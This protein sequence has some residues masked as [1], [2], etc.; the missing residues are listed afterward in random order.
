MRLMWI[1]AGWLLAVVTSGVATAQL[2]V[3][4]VATFRQDIAVD[5]R[6]GVYH[7]GALYG[8]EGS[9]QPYP[10]P[11]TRRL[12]SLDPLS[13]EVATLTDFATSNVGNVLHFT[14]TRI[15]TQRGWSSRL[16]MFSRNPV[17]NITDI[18]LTHRILDIVE[19]SDELQM[20]QT[21][22]RPNASVIAR[23]D[24]DDLTFL[25]ETHLSGAGSLDAGVVQDDGV[26]GIV[27]FVDP[28]PKV[29]ACFSIRRSTLTGERTSSVNFETPVD[30]LHLC[31]DDVTGPVTG[32]DLVL[33]RAGCAWYAVD[34][35][36]ERI[37]YKLALVD[38]I[39]GIAIGDSFVFV[40]GGG[41]GLTA[42]PQT[43]PA[44]PLFVFD[45]RNGRLLKTLMRPHGQIAAD[46]DMLIYRRWNGAVEGEVL[47]FSPEAMK[48]PVRP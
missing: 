34:S 18:T 41:R 20:L 3:E 6:D 35:K 24:R 17:E 1:I 23:F 12:V 26:I 29:M 47:R 25:G 8:F 10:H 43:R 2:R 44:F 48:Q 32:Q 39:Q 28:C 30:T 9:V 16:Q 38:P 36:A 7:D 31:R 19:R 40:L 22:Y 4:T 5:Y 46:G 45:R 42:M 37:L 11:E 21:G 13:S 14:P 33:F 27:N 15:L